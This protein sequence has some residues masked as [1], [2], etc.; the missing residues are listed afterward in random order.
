MMDRDEVL[1]IIVEC[2]CS[3]MNG[4]AVKSKEIHRAVDKIMELANP[5]L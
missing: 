2:I 4:H 3:G 5:S 1:K